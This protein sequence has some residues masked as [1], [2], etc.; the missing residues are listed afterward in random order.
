[1]SPPEPR[2]RPGLWPAPVAAVVT[3]S[4]Q[5]APSAPSDR[6]RVRISA[7]LWGS[8]RQYTGRAGK[9]PSGGFRHDRVD[10][11][12]QRG[13]VLRELLVLLRQVG[14]RLEERLELVGLALQRRHAPLPG[15]LH[16]LAVVPRQP[17]GGPF[18][19]PPPRPG[20]E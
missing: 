7:S 13:D 8:C 6:I 5:A 19:R 4:R 3:A 15:F 11:A 20:G 16:V 14:V 17:P 2:L 12:R 9:G 1:M 18:A 10:L